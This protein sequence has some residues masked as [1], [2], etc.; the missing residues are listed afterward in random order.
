MQQGNTA[1]A[2]G[3]A[4]TEKEEHGSSKKT[5]RLQDQTKKNAKW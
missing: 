3:L 2:A 5:Y 1:I 4:E